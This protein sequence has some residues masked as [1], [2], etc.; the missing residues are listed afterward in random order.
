MNNSG[1]LEE[2]SVSINGKKTNDFS[3]LSDSLPPEV[4]ILLQSQLNVIKND[5]DVRVKIAET[6]SPE[7]NDPVQKE[8]EAY[9]NAKKHESMVRSIPEYVQRAIEQREALEKIKNYEK[10]FTIFESGVALGVVTG[11]STKEEVIELLKNYSKVVFDAND[12]N[13]IFF[14][15]DI[16]FQ[17]YFNENNIVQ[18]IKFENGYKGRTTKGLKIGDNIQK[19]IDIYGQPKMKSPKGAIWDRFAIFCE[20]NIITSIRIQN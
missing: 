2:Y 13:P 14:Y 12:N 15:H 11:Q 5:N 10:I 18:E 6:I 4:A 1:I 9:L 8:I 7:K 20:N 16:S 3:M 19:A 17:V